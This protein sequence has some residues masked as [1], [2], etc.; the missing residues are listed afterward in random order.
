MSSKHILG[1]LIL[2]AGLVV[3]AQAQNCDCN[4]DCCPPC[5]KYRYEGPPKIKF[6]KGCPKPLCDPCNLP[7]YGYYPTCWGP[8]PFQ[9]DWCH[10]PVPPPAALVPPYAPKQPG[11]DEKLSPMPRKVEATPPD[12]LPPASMPTLKTEPLPSAAVGPTPLPPAEEKPAEAKTP[13]PMPV[14]PAV[15]EQVEPV[16]AVPAVD[17]QEPVKSGVT[18]PMPGVHG[19]EKQ[20]PEKPGVPEPPPSILQAEPAKEPTLNPTEPAPK[21]TAPKTAEA[22]K[23][24]ETAPKAI[25]PVPVDPAPKDTVPAPAE[26]APKDTSPAPIESA[27]KDGNPVPP[28]ALPTEMQ[29]PEIQS[30]GP[31][32]S[33]SPMPELNPPGALPSQPEMKKAEEPQAQRPRNVP[34]DGKGPM[35]RMVNSRRILL[36][37]EVADV[38]SP[39]QSVLELWFTQDGRKWYKDPM[40]VK[41]GSPYVVEVSK[42]STYGFTL[43]ARGPPA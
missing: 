38:P 30:S 8:W 27:V 2:L 31:A 19:V 23:P 15:N 33:P 6:K 28:G 24:V 34:T 10:C 22:P 39:Q 35:M 25:A 14:V 5:Y 3:P 4:K 9:Q 17:K 13:T 42:E 7:H 29:K 21:D 26:A 20:E 36:D 40:T 1:G 11:E 37:Y 41:V 12:S 18:E 16:P 32:L 43:V